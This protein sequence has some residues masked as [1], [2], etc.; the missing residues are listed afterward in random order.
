ML[1]G[2]FTIDKSDLIDIYVDSVRFC[3]HIFVIH[4]L[5]FGFR[6]ETILFGLKLYKTLMFTV[7]SIIT[8][9]LII[10]KIIYGK[11]IRN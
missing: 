8:Y 9:H 6:D 10:K 5:S 11:N 3:S 2:R 4:C 7:L 1:F